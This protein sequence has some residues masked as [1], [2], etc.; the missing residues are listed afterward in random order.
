M[1]SSEVERLNIW[2]VKAEMENPACAKEMAEL[3]KMIS[4]MKG[5]DLYGY[6]RNEL[7]NQRI[8]Q[9]A[10]GS[11]GKRRGLFNYPGAWGVYT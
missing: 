6:Y 8:S 3:R 10:Y 2:S 4:G 1:N 5:R 7:M 11:V 9:N